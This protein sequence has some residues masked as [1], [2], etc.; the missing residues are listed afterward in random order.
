MEGNKKEGKGMWTKKQTFLLGFS[1]CK[2]PRLGL[3]QPPKLYSNFLN[4]H[5]CV[6]WLQLPVVDSSMKCYMK[7]PEKPSYDLLQH[8]VTILFYY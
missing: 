7:I 8:A 2:K 3:S 6:L 1:L 4:P 5:F